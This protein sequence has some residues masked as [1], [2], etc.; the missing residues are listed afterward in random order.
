MSASETNLQGKSSSLRRYRR[1]LVLAI[2]L[3]ALGGL[4]FF[5]YLFFWRPAIGPRPAVQTITAHAGGVNAVAFTADGKTLATGGA[6]NAVRLWDVA[7]GKERATLRGHREAVTS[8]AI[9]PDG[10]TLFSGSGDKTIKVWDVATGQERTTLEGHGDWVSSLAL[11]ADGKTLA[12][13]S[14]DGTVRLWDVAAGSER[15]ILHKEP[16]DAVALTA[17]GQL[18]ACGS[19]N[20]V[21]LYAVAS[22]ELSATLSW[23]TG[24]RALAFTPDGKKLAVSAGNGGAELWDMATKK[25]EAILRRAE[26][27]DDYVKS[28]AFSP[29]GLTLA[30]GGREAVRLW[31][32]ATQSDWGVIEG[33]SGTVNAVAFS[34]DGNTLASGSKD[35]TV[36]LLDVEKIPRK[37]QLFNGLPQRSFDGPTDNLQQTVVV[38]T[39]D[40][41][42][43]N[44]KSAVWCSSFQIAW[45]HAKNDLFKE[46]VRLQGA[47]EVA[48]RLNRA[49]ASEVDLEP[50]SYYAAAGFVNDG[51]IGTIEK[52]MARRFPVA[53]HPEISSPPGGAVAYAYLRTGIKFQ[54]EF[55][56]NPQAFR[57][58]DSAG[59]ETVIRS[60]GI[61]ASEKM[62]RAGYR[63]QV[64]VLFRERGEFALDLCYSSKP[65]QLV[66]ARIKRRATLADTLADLEARIAKG[67][68]A[69]LGDLTTLLVPN[70]DWRIEHHFRELEGRLILNRV[71]RGQPTLVAF[72]VIQFQ[73]NRS[74]ADLES[75]AALNFGNGHEDNPNEFH[76]DRP[77]L[78]Y[79]K[80][81]GAAH[82]FFVM[83]V[84]NA[85]L[86]ISR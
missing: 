50:G 70:L 29:D 57:F 40:T 6:D 85:E 63:D 45:N 60:F 1:W 55:F 44:G 75:G 68:S 12:S 84:D 61:R 26:L 62:L 13:G 77:F 34:P 82:P 66:V 15:S 71:L 80:K 16:V 56:D 27:A 51:I 36:K 30:T 42:F 25:V 7:T 31:N 35:G 86:L 8:V 23:A 37:E 59:R 74:G 22:G 72:Q 17:D 39:L 76:F 73:L 49:K 69:K 4:G 67:P 47:E 28:I 5:A 65:H 81:R 14:W 18:L 78:I 83:W 21:A 64:L 24:E 2:A 46:P 32:V 3:A 53:K 79:L 58:R 41:P 11:S 10:K 33:H 54:T 48:D 52:E 19:W 9:A 38:P 20:Q 43:A